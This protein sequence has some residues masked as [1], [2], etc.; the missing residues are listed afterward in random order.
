MS[1]THAGT[2]P[3]GET[4]EGSTIG[5]GIAELIRRH[6]LVAFFVLAYTLSWC[7]WPFYAA[8]GWPVPFMAGG[9]LVAAVIVTAI[10]GGRPGLRALG[11]RLVRWRVGWRWYA[12]VLG[13]P[14][15]VLLATVALNVTLG[16]PAPSMAQLG[17]WSGLLLVFAVRLIDPLDGPVG[18]EPGW[19][20]FA[21]PGLQAGR[22]PLLATLMLGVLVAG[23]HLP[24]A[25]VDGMQPLDFLGPL[26]FA[27]VCTWVFN[28]TGGSALLTLVLHA[29]EGTIHPGALWSVG[30]DAAQAQ[31]LY[32][33][34]W[35]AA[36]AG[37]VL[38]DW[39]T[40]RSRR[41]APPA[42]GHVEAAPG[43]SAAFETPRLA[44]VAPPSIG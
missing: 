9:P 18:E 42:R 40:W 2:L 41:P 6:P 8:Y 20:G 29:A 23:W 26:A 16:A 39:R 43:L 7:G 10:T 1:T 11:A 36:A 44:P 37:V 17:P 19:R 24:L 5:S 25:F 28:R 34:V 14:L 32:A 27:F 21:L 13:L 33:V 35:C 4:K 15:A 30:A 3:V 31:A 38:F 12:V 22:S